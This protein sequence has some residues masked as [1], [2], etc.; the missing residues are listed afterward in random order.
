MLNNLNNRLDSINQLLGL[1]SG[2]SEN[3]HPFKLGSPLNNETTMVEKIESN[4]FIFLK[5]HTA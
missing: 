5:H 2:E 1:Q 3:L 4:F